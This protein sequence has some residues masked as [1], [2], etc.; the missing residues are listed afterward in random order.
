MINQENY[1]ED[2]SHITNSMLGWLDKSPAYFKSQIESQSVATEAMVFGSAFHCKV[3]ESEKFDDQ[4]YVMPK[5]DKRTK[6]GKE[7]F[8]SHLEKSGDKII[9]T[10]QQYSKI[11][12]M[13]EA[14]KSNEDLF[15]LLNSNDG[16][17]ET[18]NTWE[19]KVR[20]DMDESHTIKCK[21]LIDYRVDSDNLVVDLKTTSSVA[22]F[23]SS[24]RKFGYDRQAAYYLRGLK[25]NNLVSQDARFLFVV[26][27][28]EPPFEIAM[29][30]LDPA[31]IESANDKIDHL[32]SLY[33]KCISQ[34]YYPKRY[35]RF[36]GK[37]NLVTI[38]VEDLY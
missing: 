6:A 16:I 36:D 10:L 13:E 4:Y 8:A 31:V 35:E 5:L 24:I 38:G 32:L 9:I 12:A 22:A 1:Y 17:S 18:V 3:L 20:D 25:T 33:Q 28:K 30:E 34:E 2:K 23:T 29:F 37:L 11:I 21:S 27:E 14:I 26:V 19:E 15:K 7:E